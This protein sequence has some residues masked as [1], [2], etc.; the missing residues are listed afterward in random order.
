[1]N[2]HKCAV[3]GETFLSRRYWGVYFCGPVCR[4]RHSRK[5]RSFERDAIQII[6]QIDYMEHKRG[7]GNDHQLN[8]AFERAM[9]LINA[10]LKL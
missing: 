4:Q 2:T 6:S 1:M 8:E 7:N 10:R 9:K 3:C 5:V